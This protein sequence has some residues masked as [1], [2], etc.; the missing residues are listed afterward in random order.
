MGTGRFKLK[1]NHV[2]EL[3]GMLGETEKRKNK[4]LDEDGSHLYKNISETRSLGKNNCH[5]LPGSPRNIR[6]NVL[7]NAIKT[8]IFE[9]EYPRVI[10]STLQLFLISGWSTTGLVCFLNHCTIGKVNQ[11]VRS[12]RKSDQRKLAFH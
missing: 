10:L 7:T 4:L 8:V 9:H 2:C 1:K 3:K 11:K 6:N 12:R 5:A